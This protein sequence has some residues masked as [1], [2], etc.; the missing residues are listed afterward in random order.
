V[1]LPLVSDPPLSVVNPPVPARA[2]TTPLPTTVVPPSCRVSTLPSSRRTLFTAKPSA[3]ADAV[4]KRLLSAPN[5][6]S[7]SESDTIRPSASSVA[8]SV[9]TPTLAAG[10][11]GR[12]APNANPAGS[13]LTVT[14]RLVVVVTAK[15]PPGR[16]VIVP[17]I[18]A[19][20]FVGV[21]PVVLSRLRPKANSS[22]L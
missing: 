21:Y 15:A 12:T 1:P 17:R 20:P 2:S 11:T 22:A 16:L 6:A 3:V 4:R 10:T 18:S 9:V 5:P 14:F 8:S 19:A 7:Y 13:P